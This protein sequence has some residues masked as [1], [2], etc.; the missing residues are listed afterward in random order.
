MPAAIAGSVCAFLIFAGGGFT[1]LIMLSVFFILGTAATSWQRH[2]KPKEI[3]TARTVAQVLANGGIA[4]LAA[5]FI[6]FLPNQISILSIV[7]AAA[8]SAATADT[9]SSE[10]GMVYGKRFFNILNFKKDQLGL[11]GVVSW[12]GIIIGL[13]GSA[14]IA[15]I[16]STG[17]NN[18]NAFFVIVLSGT[19]G[20]LTDSVAG[21]AWERKGFIKNDVVN[22]LCTASAAIV[23]FLWLSLQ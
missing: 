21:A 13:F 7:M 9:L 14:L 16:Y 11:D 19:F 3:S 2:Q 18:W 1:A 17:F 22:V 4:T 6:I 10:L 20:N 5:L 12:E 23:A 8:I 15:I